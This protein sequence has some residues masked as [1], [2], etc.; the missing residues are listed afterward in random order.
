[1]NEPTRA[2]ARSGERIKRVG[3]NC[4]SFFIILLC[5]LTKYVVFFLFL[6]LSTSSSFCRFARA[7][8]NHFKSNKYILFTESTLHDVRT[9]DI[10]SIRK[11]MPNEISS[12]SNIIVYSYDFALPLWSGNR[13]VECGS[14]LYWIFQTKTNI[15]S[16][17]A[18][19]SRSAY[20]LLS[21]QV[22]LSLCLS[23]IE[24]NWKW[25]E[26]L[27][28]NKMIRCEKPFFFLRPHFKVRSIRLSFERT[29]D[30]T[31]EWMNIAFEFHP[32][33]SFRI[34]ARPF[35]VFNTFRKWVSSSWLRL[36]KVT[37]RQMQTQC[38]RNRDWDRGR[39][40]AGW[41]YHLT[42]KP[43]TYLYA[44]SVCASMI[45]AFTCYQRLQKRCPFAFI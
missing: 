36:P 42:A 1:M 12:N 23:S 24:S 19:T 37:I 4:F 32:L 9:E 15:R 6:L 21:S 28:R 39:E 14:I 20:K 8:T 3:K 7:R 30:R 18:H 22:Y 11:E 13:A 27:K 38:K 33:I 16:Y 45:V 25:L 41:F 10:N 2:V 29:M 26:K 43:K 5:V 34:W 40:N 17:R 44:P 35:I 31:N